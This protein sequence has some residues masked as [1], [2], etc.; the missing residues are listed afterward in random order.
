M[1]GKM[2]ASYSGCVKEGYC[3]KTAHPQADNYGNRWA[4]RGSNVFTTIDDLLESTGQTKVN[5]TI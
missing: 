3:I 4:F 1:M 5:W 2:A